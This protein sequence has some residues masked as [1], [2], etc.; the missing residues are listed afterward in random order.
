[1]DNCNFVLCNMFQ[2]GVIECCDVEYKAEMDSTEI[3]IRS[4]MKGEVV[5]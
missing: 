1:M 4:C 5:A 3:V 2:A